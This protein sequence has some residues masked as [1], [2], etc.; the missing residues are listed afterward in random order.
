MYFFSLCVPL[1]FNYLWAFWACLLSIIWKLIR[2]RGKSNFFFIFFCPLTSAE[3]CKSH[4]SHLFRSILYA[5][6]DSWDQTVQCNVFWDRINTSFSEAFP[7]AISE[8]GNC[9]T[10]EKVRFLVVP[11]TQTRSRN[12]IRGNVRTG[13]LSGMETSL[14]N[15]SEKTENVSKLCLV[16]IS[17]PPNSK[18][19]TS[20][21][22]SLPQSVQ[23]GKPQW[24]GFSFSYVLLFLTT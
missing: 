9:V 16:H 17:S 23:L 21:T 22:V 3:C 20:S 8:V 14:S 18:M 13:D 5:A 15:R 19:A 4:G 10:K 1:K 2:D 24:L 11:L 12:I 6:S 7:L